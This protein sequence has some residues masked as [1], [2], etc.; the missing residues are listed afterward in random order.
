MT[1][2]AQQRIFRI[3]GRVAGV[4]PAS[5]RHETLLVADLNIDSPR[6]LMLLVELEDTFGLTMSD[7]AAAQM[8][9]AGDILDYLE[10]R[11]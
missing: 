9:T 4:D 5:I 3:I 11:I 10:S 1:E 6:A 2:Q 8:Q 7:N